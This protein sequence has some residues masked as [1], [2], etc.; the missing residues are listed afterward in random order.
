[1]NYSTSNF[2]CDILYTQEKT[3]SEK[4]RSPQSEKESA[5]ELTIRGYAD[6]AERLAHEYIPPANIWQ[7][8]KNEQGPDR[9]KLFYDIKEELNRRNKLRDEQEKLIRLIRTTDRKETLLSGALK[10]E[11]FHKRR[12]DESD[13]EDQGND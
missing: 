12:T 2:D 7:A 13:D 4:Y 5:Y 3:M 10:N 1:M 9:S 6:V 11:L 8:L